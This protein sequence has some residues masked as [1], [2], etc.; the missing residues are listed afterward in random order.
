[1]G[2]KIS[3]EIPFSQEELL[4]LEQRFRRLDKDGSGMLEPNEFFDIPE[5]AQNPLVQRVISVFDKNKDGNISFYEF[6]T[7]ISKLTEAGSE[8]DKMR[9]LFSIYDIENDGFI[10][11]GELFKV[12][13]MMVG[14]NLT[15][16]QLQ[17]LVDR[18]II[19]ADE[20]FDGKISYEEF[21]KMIRNLEIG[22]KLTLHFK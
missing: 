13:K 1:M 8:E 6:V 4:M 16:V 18:T 19:R 2:V 7:G 22:D 21:C 20:D 11:N 17:Q 5:L 10:S 14:N 9:F 12:L 3:Q 15:D